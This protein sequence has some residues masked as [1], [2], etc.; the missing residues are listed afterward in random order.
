MHRARLTGIPFWPAPS[1]LDIPSIIFVWQAIAA[2]TEAAAQPEMER[3]RAKRAAVA[4][5][6]HTPIRRYDT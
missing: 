5:Q 1:I 4:A 3:R 2:E 6:T